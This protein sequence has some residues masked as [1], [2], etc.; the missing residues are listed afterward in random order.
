[1]RKDLCHL[2]VQNPPEFL[3]VAVNAELSD[4]VFERGLKRRKMPFIEMYETEHEA[5]RA[6]RN[7][8]PSMFTILARVM[9]EDGYRFCVSETGEW[10]TDEIPARYLRLC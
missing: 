4:K 1:M 3:F 10:L 2:S 6:I 5:R 9:A 7:G 8:R